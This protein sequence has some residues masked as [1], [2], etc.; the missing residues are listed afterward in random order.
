MNDECASPD[1]PVSLSIYVYSYKYSVFKTIVSED[2][3]AIHCVLYILDLIP[4]NSSY[5]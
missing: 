4:T 3:L 1:L 5:G 2:E